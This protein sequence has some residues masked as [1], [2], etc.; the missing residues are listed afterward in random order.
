MSELGI[1]PQQ[2]ATPLG[3]ML[4]FLFTDIQGSTG[5]WERA[6]AGMRAALA[7]HD[8][9][10]RA[11]IEASGGRVFK[12]MGDAFYAAFPDV[13]SAIA[14][15]LQAQR[16]L[17]QDGFPEVGG[18]AVR[19]VIHA[20]S[21]EAR[22]G[23]YFGPPLNRA[24]RMLAAGHGGQVLVS[25]AAAA[26][27]SDSLTGG[28]G[29]LDLG[30]HRLKDLAEPQEIHQLAAPDLKSDFPPLR[31]LS[32]SPNNLPRPATALIGR[33]DEL[34][35]IKA[36]LGSHR[37]V[38]LVGSG[39]VGKTRISMEIGGALVEAYPDGV[40]LVELAPVSDPVLVPELVASLFGIAIS[41]GRA[42]L[43]AV[44][45]ILRQKRTL[46]IIDNCEHLVEAVACLADAI[47]RHCPGVSLL[48][49]S[50]EPLAIAGEGTYRMP[51][52]SFPDRP[53][54]ISAAHAME[55]GAVRLFIERA[56]SIL[57]DF[58]IA[59]CNAPAV[60]AICKR[61][62]GVALAI[63]LAAPRLKML[64]PEALAK[65]LDDRFKLLTGG[66]RTALP[67][68][69]TLKALIDWSYNLLSDLEQVLLRRLAVFAGGWTVESAGAIAAGDEIEE[70][71]IFDLLASLVDKSLVV[72]DASG[73]ETRYRLLES[74]RQYGLSKL[75]EHGDYEGWPRLADYLSTCFAHAEA[76]W[77]TT[78]TEPWLAAYGSELDNLRA[79]L[80]WAFGPE[81]KASAGLDLIGRSFRLFME[82]S[83]LPEL[84]RWLQ[85]AFTRI[86]ATTPD[87][88]AARI[89]FGKAWT[90]PQYGDREEVPFALRAAELFRASGDREGE[91]VA[92]ARAG[93]AHLTNRVTAEGEALLRQAEALLMPQ[94]GTLLG[95]TKHHAMWLH[96]LGA[97]HHF[98]GD[99][100]LARR[101]AEQAASLAR[102][103]GDRKGFRN[104]L[105][106][107]GEIH[108]QAGD[109]AA[110]VAS[111]K[112]AIEEA[113][114][115]NDGFTL[116]HTRTNIAAHLLPMDA[117]REARDYA[118][119]AIADARAI[120]QPFFVT[121]AVEHLA[122]IAALTGQPDRAAR[123]VGYSSRW[124]ETKQ[125]TRQDTE[126]R[127]YDRLVTILTE[128][129]PAE[130]CRRLEDEGAVW[131][132]E[133]AISEALEV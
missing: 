70:W 9:M 14:A 118:R 120:A 47:L 95:R 123:L 115:E 56:R 133:Q 130:E 33:E 32:A 52:L 15:A 116:A 12:T 18:I 59:D 117:V 35:E 93:A 38:T 42:P 3:G 22:D 76:A 30:A 5:R 28:F 82:L 17:Q 92:L 69:Q 81:G 108:G 97:M 62:D 84:A 75:A 112:L 27:V 68:Q 103:T 131:N 86:D 26:L 126:R 100:E 23:D 50:R 57:P 40:W 43:D 11:A 45:S 127:G 87:A 90:F 91:G 36:L 1:S 63:E 64:N 124:Y 46:L 111:I 114:A 24:A 4:A 101:T 98:A 29:L 122:L 34:R 16:Q 78:G 39:G 89:W 54:G 55:F 79:S 74:T 20:G 65:R 21:A 19:M 37:L 83:L 73:A 110:A 25:E 102:E 49:S 85:V 41:A 66:S 121:V 132:E 8:G 6:P 13:G 104:I 61:L 7:R 72:A 125:M 128:Q 44:T 99:A 119:V 10:L 113:L 71:Q 67:R 94:P 2:D 96:Y 80:D 129:M 53:E 51:S 31:S 106:T 77:P 109:F 48:A 107:L 88:V 58:A 105:N 60:S